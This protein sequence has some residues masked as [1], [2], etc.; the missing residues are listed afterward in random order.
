M[1]GG[2]AAHT[3]VQFVD[4]KAFV[5][6]VPF[7]VWVWKKDVKIRGG[8]T[9]SQLV[10]LITGAEGVDVGE[11]AAHMMRDPNFVTSPKTRTVNTACCEI[12]DLGFSK[13]V[14]TPEL[15][16]KFEEIGGL[17]PMDTGPHLR[18]QFMEQH[19]GDWAFVAMRVTNMSFTSR[20]VFILG[21]S[22]DTGRKKKLWIEG[23]SVGD[24]GRW[25]P[26]LKVI[27]ALPS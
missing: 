3:R 8:I 12:G 20:G 22:N 16:A 11:R 21:C 10:S 17:C 4:P 27:I 5:G 14:T 2:I 13:H 24:N 1:T 6:S 26:K 25:N 7:P 19:V 18:H 23:C 9:G 15:W